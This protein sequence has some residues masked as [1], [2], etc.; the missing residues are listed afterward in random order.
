MVGAP[1]KVAAYDVTL[2]VAAEGQGIC[3]PWRVDGREGAVPEEEAMAGRPDALDQASMAARLLGGRS[4]KSR[5][6]D[7][8]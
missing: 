1:G 3:R 7:E 8:P 2:R 5:F 6:F 4:T